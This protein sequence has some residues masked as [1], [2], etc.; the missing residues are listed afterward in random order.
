MMV[1]TLIVASVNPATME[2]N[3]KLKLMNVKVTPVS[4]AANAMT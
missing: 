2:Y 1:I 4:M 3:V